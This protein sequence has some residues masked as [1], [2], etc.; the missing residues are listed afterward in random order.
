M[1]SETVSAT[2]P[3]RQ[4]IPGVRPGT[5]GK[6]RMHTL[7][8]GGGRS[9]EQIGMRWL[10]LRLSAEWLNNMGTVAGTLHRIR[11]GIDSFTGEGRIRS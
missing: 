7:Q 8:V 3:E 9:I 2:L 6:R 5:A 11:Q 4:R 10:C 1:H